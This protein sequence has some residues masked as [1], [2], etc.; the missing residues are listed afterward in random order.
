MDTDAPNMKADAP[1][2]N[3]RLEASFGYLLVLRD[4]VVWKNMHCQE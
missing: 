3:G 4:V 1:A 2:G